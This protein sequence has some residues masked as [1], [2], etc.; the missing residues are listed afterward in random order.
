MASGNSRLRSFKKEKA[1][2][3]F[4]IYE[5]RFPHRGRRDSFVYLS[6]LLLSVTVALA[7]CSPARVAA[8][9]LPGSMGKHSHSSGI[10]RDEWRAAAGGGAAVSVTPAAGA[11][12]S[13]GD[14]AADSSGAIAPVVGEFPV[15]GDG[16]YKREEPLPSFILHQSG[17]ARAEG[18]DLSASGGEE[19]AAGA[20][21]SAAQGA[22]EASAAD[23]PAPLPEDE[24]MAPASEAAEESA[25][26]EAAAAGD[27][28]T[29]SAGLLQ[30]T[31]Q[32]LLSSLR[33]LFSRS[34]AACT[35]AN[36]DKG[37]AKP[38][39]RVEAAAPSDGFVRRVGRQLW[40]R[41]KPFYVNGWNTYWL[42][43]IASIPEKKYLV[44]QALTQGRSM[45]LT[46]CRTGAFYD[47]PGW[48]ALQTRPG[49]F[50]E[51]TF[52]ALDYV[53]FTA[54]R[55]GVR[56]HMVLN[57]N[58]DDY[59]GKNQYIKWSAAAGGTPP[60][61]DTAFFV[62]PL[63]RTFYKNFIKA[64]IMRRN[65]LTGQL[66]R[67]DPTIFGWELMNE[68]RVYADPSGDVLQAWITDMASYLKSLDPNHLL[69]IG[70]E[71]FYGPS[72]PERAKAL[73]AEWYMMNVGT[74]FVRNNK[75]P[76][77]DIASVHAYANYRYS[78]SAWS[79]KLAYFKNFVKGHL[80][81]GD[82]V[83]NMPVLIGEFGPES[84]KKLPD[85]SMARRNEVYST[86]Y[87]IVLESVKKG[88]SAG[89]TL[90]WQI[91]ADDL[92]SW[93]DGKGR[94][95]GSKTPEHLSFPP[96]LPLPFSLHL[97][98]LPAPAT[99]LWQIMADDLRSWDDGK[100]QWHSSQTPEHLPFSP[101]PS[102]LF[103]PA[104]ATMFWQIMADDLRSW[105]D[106]IAVF[107]SDPA[108]AKTVSIISAQSKAIAAATK[109]L[110]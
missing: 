25:A 59:G 6:P 4:S 88:G 1:A 89:A 100:G 106:G 54:K 18:G 109:S 80:E 103:L 69:S 31:P 11:D 63:C 67:D 39:Y 5:R 83:L 44:N 90:F 93:D 12:A 42:M 77:I 102:S 72:T 53:L 91:K 74:D 75:V 2:S 26:E 105:D 49:V 60:A 86:L 55:F 14:A 32:G 15:P 33:C 70:S 46:V 17:Y 76:G 24:E 82:G 20:D 28:S 13:F 43:Y 16:P 7:L 73:N 35:L 61:D 22:E 23:A 81:D 56:L 9:R 29:S 84:I 57:G 64:V 27:I 94:W 10:M 85:G 66:Y 34:D 104:P 45:G 41:G 30:L 8:V 52:K 71:G 37:K 97:P 107:A 3:R 36:A 101:S 50:D 48:H 87:Q 95:H 47:G 99:M 92:R 79:D 108:H 78:V 38:V 110:G 19:P 65:T 98:S 96:H 40:L 68:P 58:W 62:D 21:E 51:N